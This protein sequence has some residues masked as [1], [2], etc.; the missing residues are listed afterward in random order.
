MADIRY[1]LGK[2]FKAA[3]GISS[4]VYITRPI[5]I[6]DRKQTIGYSG[7]KVI[8]EEEAEQISWLGTPII[9]PITFKA[10]TYKVYDS[11]GKLKDAEFGDFMLPSA[12]L[13]E[14]S[15]AKNITRTEVLGSN[16]TVK[17]IYG[18][19]DWQIRM[20]GVCLPEPGRSETDQKNALLAWNE[21]AGSIKVDG[22][23]FFE[24]GIDRIAI[25]DIQFSQVQAKPKVLPFEITAVS[26]D[27]IELVLDNLPK[28]SVELGDMEIMDYY[29]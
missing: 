28:G 20:R 25:T 11:K 16:G 10:E 13:V 19:D 9:F 7:V 29:E 1:D 21:I 24:K 8:E 15:R 26:D 2:I 27:P 22:E 5:S 4:P 18:F 17:E 23:L 12:T 6:N 14:F 3:F